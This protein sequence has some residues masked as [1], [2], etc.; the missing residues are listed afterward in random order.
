MEGR[1]GRGCSCCWAGWG[2]VGGRLSQP[3]ST[4]P[5][6]SSRFQPGG[7]PLGCR[8]PRVT[9]TLRPKSL[10][11]VSSLG[12]WWATF[13]KLRAAG[14][15]RVQDE[16]EARAR[17]EHGKCVGLYPVVDT[18]AR[19]QRTSQE[20]ERGKDTRQGLAH[21]RPCEPRYGCRTLSRVPG[22]VCR[23]SC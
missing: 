3:V 12:Q 4:C 14:E 9:L 19:G 15:V 8:H 5:E 17:K 22:H 21:D 1:E 2:Q 23:I 6:P 10:R 7:F 20:V 16:W 11:G 18:R 13:S